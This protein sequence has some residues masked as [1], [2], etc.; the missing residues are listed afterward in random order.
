MS[1]A[2]RLRRAREK[3]N[4]SAYALSVKAG[5]LP[6][7]VAKLE[8]RDADPRLSTARKLAD[9]LGISLDELAPSQNTSRRKS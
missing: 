2:Q 5:M 8:T 3:Q 4:L 6:H 9:A 1:F 7:L